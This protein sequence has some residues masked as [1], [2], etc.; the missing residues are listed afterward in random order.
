MKDVQEATIDN[1]KRA[2]RRKGLRDRLIDIGVVA[3]VVLL[4]HM[5]LH[6]HSQPY[7]DALGNLSAGHA[8]LNQRIRQV[9]AGDTVALSSDTHGLEGILE[10]VTVPE[11]FWRYTTSGLFLWENA[12][13]AKV[14]AHE[15]PTG[16]MPGQVHAPFQRVNIKVP[17]KLWYTINN[18][19]EVPWTIRFER[20]SSA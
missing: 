14:Q 13:S 19:W 8:A 6:E 16:C 7:R 15:N 11:G 2:V 17:C 5:A 18:R 4:V 9:W 20:E 12:E 3:I 10:A 1:A